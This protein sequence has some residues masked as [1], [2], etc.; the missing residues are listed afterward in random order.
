M[1]RKYKVTKRPCADRKKILVHH[2]DK[3]GGVVDQESDY[4][5]CITKAFEVLGDPVKRR[6]YDS[7]DPMF[8]DIVPSKLPKGKEHHL[9]KTFGPVFEAN[10]RWSTKQPVPSLGHENSSYEQVNAFYDFW[11][12]FESWREYSYLDEEDKERGQDREERRCIEVEN[13]RAREKRKREEMARIRQL[14]DNAFAS[15]QRVVR[16]KEE[17]KQKKLAEKRAREEARRAKIEQEERLKREQEEKE[18]LERQAEQEALKAKRDQEKKEKEAR[19]KQRKKLE[20]DLEN[21]FGNFVEFTADAKEQVEYM[22]NLNRI[23]VVYKNDDHKLVEFKNAVEAATAIDDRK[24]I[25][26]EYLEK[27]R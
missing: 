12:N 1:R 14:V 15:D 16:F 7:C 8:D 17:Q 9:Y 21:L 18:R 24:R 5:A 25:F 11:Y 10:A 3:R 19:K 26:H 27:T 6:S 22:S 4:F 20:K 2:P 13:K 23:V